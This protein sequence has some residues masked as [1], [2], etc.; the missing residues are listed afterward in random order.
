MLNDRMGQ[1]LDQALV[2]RYQDAGTRYRAKVKRAIRYR[3]LESCSSRDLI[4]LP[5]HRFFA[6]LQITARMFR[7]KEVLTAAKHL[8][9]LLGIHIVKNCGVITY[10]HF[11]CKHHQSCLIQ[12]PKH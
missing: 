12:E 2:L 6:R 11:M 9:C 7:T 10:V 8:A 5:L 4:V 3:V 1:R